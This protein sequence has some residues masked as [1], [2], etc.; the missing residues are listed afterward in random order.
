MTNYYF[1]KIHKTNNN[2]SAIRLSFAHGDFCPWNMMFQQ[3]MVLLYDWEMSKTYPIGCDLFTYIFQTAFLLSP[4]KKINEIVNENRNYI[5]KYF[6]YFTTEQ[7]PIYL[8][9]FIEEKIKLEIIKDKNSS[10]LAQYKSLF[11]ELPLLR[12]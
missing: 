2:S 9:L 10:L 6:D 12:L 5:Q 11:D 4:T 8:K 3:N 1:I 7:I